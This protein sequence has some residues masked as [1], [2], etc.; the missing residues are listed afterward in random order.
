MRAWWSVAVILAG[1]CSSSEVA[2]AAVPSVQL[3]IQRAV[4]GMTVRVDGSGFTVGAPLALSLDSAQVAAL[5]VSARGSFATTVSVPIDE[6]VGNHVL[7][8]SGV[9]GLLAQTDLT[10]GPP[11]P[12]RFVD[13]AWQST[14][15]SGTVHAAVYLPAGYDVGS[16][17]YPV[18][19]FLHGLP[20]NELAYKTW[21]PLLQR[22]LDTVGFPA[23]GVIPQASRAGDPDPEFIDWG[24]TR[25]W[26][27][28]LGSEL[29]QFIDST[30]RTIADRRGRA[31]VGVSAGGY[32][33]MLLGL[34]HLDEFSAV[35]SWSGYFRPTDPAGA[36]TLNLG[37]AS[38]NLRASAFTF[39]PSLA[40]TLARMPTFLGFYVGRQDTRFRAD[41][42]HFHR[43]LVAAGV[44]HTF[45][46]YSS[47]HT[48]SLWNSRA[49]QW[50]SYALQML[51]RAS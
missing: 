34:H 35:E 22:G 46:Q 28:A 5:T 11:D 44:A 7:G 17:H 27:A 36:K 21:E 45:A 39:V 20:A 31:L 15:L 2:A 10:V 9:N 30:F 38:A 14:A 13:V 25:E 43:E 1:F 42:I 51:D 23:I 12:A 16:A 41:N 32:G 49:N 19:Y 18:V 3:A 24:Q 33:A 6:A 26:E 47:A 48:F 40:P 37:S 29:P 8:V 4:P 50:L